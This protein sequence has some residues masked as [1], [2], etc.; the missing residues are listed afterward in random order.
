MPLTHWEY[1]SQAN[2]FETNAPCS[3]EQGALVISNAHYTNYHRIFGTLAANAHDVPPEAAAILI[4]PFL[5]STIVATI[6]QTTINTTTTF[7]D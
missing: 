5:R 6:P 4:C 7:I 3:T 2:T 1:N